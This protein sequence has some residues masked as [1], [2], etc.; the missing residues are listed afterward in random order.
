M[1]LKSKLLLRFPPVLILFAAMLFLPAGTLRFWQGWAWLAVLFVPVSF[2]FVYLYRHDRPL[3]ERRMKMK[4]EVGEQKLF[5]ILASLVFFPAIVLAGFDHRFGWSR[6]YLRPVP[7]WLALLSLV[8]IIGSF[9]LIFWVMRVNS[10][11][12]RTIQVETG[13]TVVSTGPYHFMRH[14][15]YS[16]LG[17]FFIFTPLALGSFILLPAF[18]LLIPAFIYRLLNEEKILRQELPGY[19]EY[20]FRTR[21]RLIPFVW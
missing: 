6:T 18:A 3:L 15:M 16:A 20:C 2:F 8:L 11:A 9:S 7:L 21:F 13:Q 14:P 12:S 1:S 5:R 17:V 4:E 19:S 10:F